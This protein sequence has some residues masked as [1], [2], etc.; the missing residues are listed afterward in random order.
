MVTLLTILITIVCVIL[1]ASVL[2]QN[3]KGGGIDSAF[4]GT[5]VHHQIGVARS[6]YLIEKITWGLA[7]ALFILCITTAIFVNV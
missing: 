2:I 5:S 7:T 4:G 1:M 3:P 6:G